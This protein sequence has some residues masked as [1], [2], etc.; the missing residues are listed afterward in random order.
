MNKQQL[1]FGQK[2]DEY[3]YGYGYCQCGCGSTTYKYHAVLYRKFL[4][5]HSRRRRNTKANSRLK[6][7]NREIVTEDLL[8]WLYF[9]ENNTPYEIAELVKCSETSVRNLF[10]EYSIKTRTKSKSRII[11]L[12]KGKL[13]AHKYYEIDER[14][15]SNWSPEMAW[16]LGLIYT[17]GSMRGN[18]IRLA[19]N[20]RDVIEKVTA[21]LKYSKPI[22]VLSYNNKPLY[23]VEFHR[24]KIAGDLM[25]LGIHQA[26]S[27]TLKF[28]NIPS[29]MLRHFIRG[30]WDGDGGFGEKANSVVAYYTTSSK[31]FIN[32]LKMK[33]FEAGVYRAN[34]QR[35][36]SI[37]PSEWRKEVLALKELYPDEK[38]PCRIRKRGNQN[39]YDINI[40]LLE[41]LINLYTY[42]YADVDESIY[43]ERKYYKFHNAL[44][45]NNPS[46]K[47]KYNKMIKKKDNEL[48]KKWNVD[49]KKM[50]NIKIYEKGMSIKDKEMI[51]TE[52]YKHGM[53][54]KD[55]AEKSGL[56]PNKIRWNLGKFN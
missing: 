10:K 12:K 11:A 35:P 29:E 48:Y 36:K 37:T 43:M 15:F 39:T 5:L 33:L 4:P 49:K 13:P 52:F 6:K 51:N 2:T 54:I 45:N 26:K 9:D 16:V 47:N 42:F 21:H 53:S 17:D 38:Y 25:R 3:P 46:I 7:I 41:A 40:S 20:D 50:M 23:C 55:I 44:F 19:M 18:N 22:S 32:E 56:S 31:N 34:L 8:R 27:F 14:F 30:C 28:P 24:E 1:I